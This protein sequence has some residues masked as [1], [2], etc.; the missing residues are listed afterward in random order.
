MASFSNHRFPPAEA[1]LWLV[2]V[3]SPHLHPS[4]QEALPLRFQ[5]WRDGPSLA[6]SADLG[7]CRS[8]QANGF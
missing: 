2:W 7:F 4:S 3:A 5:L 6:V 1:Q 8:Q